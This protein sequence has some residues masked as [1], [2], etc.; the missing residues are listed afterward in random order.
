MLI[1]AG[2]FCSPVCPCVL[3]DEVINSQQQL[4]RHG[5][6]SPEKKGNF[7]GKLTEFLGNK[8]KTDQCPKMNRFVLF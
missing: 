8:I 7:S 1:Y 3:P 5:Q 4:C 6:K 2:S